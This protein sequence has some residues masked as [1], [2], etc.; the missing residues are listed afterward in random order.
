VT[1]EPRSRTS[2]LRWLGEGGGLFCWRSKGRSPASASWYPG[3]DGQVHT[4]AGAALYRGDSGIIEQ[5]YGR[6]I[7]AREVVA[8]D[9]AGDGLCWVR[10]TGSAT[11]GS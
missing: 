3:T 1:R 10:L 2:A 4:F 8:I 11:S 5:A 9:E 7:H 6:K